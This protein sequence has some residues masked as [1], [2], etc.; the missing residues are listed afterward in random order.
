MNLRLL[1]LGT[2]ALLAFIPPSQAADCTSLALSVIPQCAQHCF[3]EGAP[4]IGCSSL[5]FGCQ[6]RQRQAMHDTIDGCVR[7][8]CPA[9]GDYQKV[10]D[11]ADQ[12]ESTLQVKEVGLIRSNDGV[13]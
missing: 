6:C 11:G 7:S 9:E 4:K 8:S 1:P 3:L 12:G 13:V 2:A 5:E 10:L